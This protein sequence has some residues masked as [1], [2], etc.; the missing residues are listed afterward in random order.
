[1][2]CCLVSL[3]CQTNLHQP[4]LPLRKGLLLGGT[5]G[6][7]QG[8]IFASNSMVHLPYQTT[9]SSLDFCQQQS[10]LMLRCMPCRMVHGL[11]ADEGNE[12]FIRPREASA[13]SSSLQEQQDDTRQAGDTAAR[14]S[15]AGAASS[16]K[17]LLNRS[18]VE[19]YQD[20]HEAFEV[21]LCCNAMQGPRMFQ[22]RNATVS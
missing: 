6:I 14:Q 9:C 2:C 19:T 17:H 10:R 7:S 11:L 13:H 1:M 21:R 12:F 16:S 20:W 18:E 22:R 8:V 15:A 5:A 3:S 4:C